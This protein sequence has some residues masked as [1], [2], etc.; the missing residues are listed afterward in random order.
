[1]FTNADTHAA[2]PQHMVVAV[3]GRPQA[4]HRWTLSKR[5][6]MFELSAELDAKSLRIGG[7]GGRDKL[8]DELKAMQIHKR[9][10]GTVVISAPPG[11]HDDLV[12]AAA[13]CVFGCRMLGGVSR[14]R[15]LI[16]RRAR[17]LTG[18]ICECEVAR[19]PGCPIIEVFSADQPD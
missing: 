9:A 1:V 8:I 12:S 5:D 17:V 7:A 14:P 13:L 4:L 19:R 16:R 18:A 15:R 6:A 11:K 3:A 10:S 2:Q